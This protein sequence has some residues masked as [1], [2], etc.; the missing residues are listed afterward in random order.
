M[1]IYISKR[2]NNSCCSAF[3]QSDSE[4]ELRVMGAL[5]CERTLRVR[6]A[7]AERDVGLLAKTCHLL[8][9]AEAGKLTQ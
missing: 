1:L 9:S 2:D 4:I 7:A 5:L 8:L 6:C 3:Q